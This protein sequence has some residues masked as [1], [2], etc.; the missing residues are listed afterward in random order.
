MNRLFRHFIIQISVRLFFVVVGVVLL[1]SLFTL[2]EIK[3]IVVD[4]PTVDFRFDRKKFSNNL[5]LLRT[6]LLQAMTQQSYP[7]ILRIHFQKKFPSTLKIVVEMRTPMA[8]IITQGGGVQID[9]N[10]VIFEGKLDDSLPHIDMPL[11]QFE[12]GKIVKDAKIIT[13]LAFIAEL[14]HDE[15]IKLVRLSDENTLVVTF[16]D[17]EVLI[18]ASD[19]GSQKA[20]TLQTILKGFRMKGSVPA[21]ID[22]RFDK[23]IIV[24]N[25]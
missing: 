22:L 18:R 14:R 21:R 9:E 23:P 5:L 2:F 6:D 20:H 4:P 12:L 19:D 7:N 24:S 16:S 15:A 10:L 8:Q 17:F 11:Q 13:A 1:Y 25:N 3:T